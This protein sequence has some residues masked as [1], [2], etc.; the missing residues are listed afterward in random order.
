MVR[1]SSALT[2]ALSAIRQNAQAVLDQAVQVQ[3]SLPTSAKIRLLILPI[4]PLEKTPICRNTADGNATAL[5]ALANLTQT[6]NNLLEEG[7]RSNAN[8]L[9]WDVVSLYVAAGNICIDFPA[10]LVF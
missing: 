9:Y 5:R 6:Y 2:S 4:P 1:R 3:Q 7:V 8:L 10:D